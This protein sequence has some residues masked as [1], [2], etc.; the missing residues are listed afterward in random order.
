MESDRGAIAATGRRGFGVAGALA[1]PIVRELARAA[2]TAGYATFWVNDTPGG[3]GLAALREAATATATIRL[4]IGVVPL[5]RQPPERIAAR[6]AELGLP[7]E[8]LIL[9]IGAGSQAGGLA[10]VRAGAARLRQLTAATVVVGALGPKMCRVAGEA[11]DGVLLNWLTA[12]YVRPSAELV[13]AA[14]AEAGR[15]RPRIDAYVRTALGPA[16]IERVREEAD[17]YA[18]FPAYAAHFGRMDVAAMATT[19]TGETREEIR[20]GL[21]AFAP[22]LDETVVR[23]IVAEE[24]AVAYLALLTAAAPT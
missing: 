20:R 1:H 4:G 19:V 10:R 22:H 16:A 23:A 11:A 6:V 14:A 21:A 5:D 24:S 2:E 7:T 8:R 3:D 17:R 12:D 9:G 18:A 13:H 15:P